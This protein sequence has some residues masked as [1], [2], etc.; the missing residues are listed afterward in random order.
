MFMTTGFL[1]VAVHLSLYG[2]N[3]VVWGRVGWEMNGRG[4]DDQCGCACI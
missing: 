3:V 1:P 4:D 2:A